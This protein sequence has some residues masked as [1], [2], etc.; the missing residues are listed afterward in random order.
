MNRFDDIFEF[1]GQ[2]RSTSGAAGHTG[3]AAGDGGETLRHRPWVAIRWRC[4]GA[5]SRI[6]RNREGTAYT[7]RCPRCARPVRL[8][9]GPGGTSARFFEAE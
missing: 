8:R 4:C 9:V 6:Y 5:Y 1:H 7:G 3:G 2:V